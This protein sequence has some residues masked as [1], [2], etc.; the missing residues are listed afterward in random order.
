M[1]VRL[2]SAAIRA[3]P[4]TGQTGRQ[5]PALFEDI[6]PAVARSIAESAGS[7]PVVFKGM[8]RRYEKGWSMSGTSRHEFHELLHVRK[9]RLVFDIE[10][11]KVPVERGGTLVIRP[12]TAH[13][14]RLDESGVELVVLYFGFTKPELG[15][16]ESSL[17]RTDASDE[18]PVSKATIEK[19]LNFAAGQEE[20]VEGAKTAPYLMIRGRQREDIEA[21]IDRVLRE[22]REDA[23]GKDLM[24]QFLAMELLVALS[25]GL[26]EEW[27]ENLR[28]RTGKARELVRIARDFIVENHD[29]ELS[30]ADIAGYVF[31][32]QGYFT[33]AFREEAGLSPMAFLIQ[34]RVEHAC[35]LLAQPEFKVGGI[36]RQVGFASPQRFN[37]AFRKQTGMTPMAYRRRVLGDD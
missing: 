30:V 12:G 36:A 34:V 23:Y 11:H 10:G 14:L 6:L 16:K 13:T 9:G 37:A 18:A 4:R 32:S 7:I 22:S 35:R 28:V 29:R 3:H 8:E 33:R 19:F 26:R 20:G 15:A 21:I 2:R 5:V 1:G 24:M 31:L 25:R 27:E 17:F